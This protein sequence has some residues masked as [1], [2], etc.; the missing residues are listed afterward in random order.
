MEHINEDVQCTRSALGQTQKSGCSTG[1]SA[2]PS[3]ADIVSHAWQVR[4]GP[5]LLQNSFWGGERKFLRPLMHL[6]R[7]DVRDRTISFHSKSITDLRCGVEKRRSGRE[8]QRS[9]FARFLGLSNFRLLQQYRPEAKSTA[10]IRDISSRIRGV[11]Y[12]PANLIGRE[13]ATPW[14]R[15]HS[16]AY[17]RG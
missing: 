5:I 3:I 17:Q 16:Y 14:D 6:T 8:V 4:K 10:S 12:D 2:L 11:P 15:G 9:T 13:A 1:R 7:G